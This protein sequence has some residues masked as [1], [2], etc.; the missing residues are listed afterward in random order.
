MKSKEIKIAIMAILAIVLIYIGITFMKGLKFTSSDNIYYVEMSNVGGLSKSGEVIANGMN[1]G[2]V[3]NIT[4]NPKTQKLAVAVELNDGFL[5]PQNSTASISKD[6]LGAPKLNII[7]GSNP[8]KLLNI[9][10]TIQGEG[11][12]DIMAA[13]GALIPQLKTIL[14]K[15][16]SITMAINMLT[17][18]PSLLASVHN[19][20]YVT[21][22]LRTSTDEVNSL[23]SN[24]V[25]RLMNNANAICANLESTTSKLNN[26]DIE[27]IASDAHKAIRNASSTM[28]ELTLFTNRLNNPNSTLGRLMNDDALYTH[29]DTTM[30]NA[31]L[32]LED[33][34]LHP[35]RYVH[36]SVFGK[37]SK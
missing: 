29:L 7:L 14:V 20:E 10:D 23:L 8:D 34:R 35:S 33:L 37:K 28:E 18:D 30:Q 11:N 13:A 36:F 25:P 21:E 9:G 27:G 31:S 24:D 6:M 17:N 22:N 26:I 5:L 16:D 3:K 4:Y 12:N 19:I 15:I 32:L 2:M 1:I